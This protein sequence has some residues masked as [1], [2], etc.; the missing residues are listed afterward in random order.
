MAGDGANAMPTVAPMLSYEDAGA[1]SAWLARAFGF[2]ERFRY[3]E[4]DGRVSHVELAMD[5]GVVMLATPTPDYESPKRH[6]ER[7]EA[8]ARWSRSPYVIDGVLV[9]VDDADAHCERARAAGAT[10][11]SEPED[12][13]HGDRHY[14]AED[15]EGH[16]WMFAQRL[17]DVAPEEWGAVTA[18]NG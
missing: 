3:T 11:L 13:P 6:R 17:T 5:D 8:A 10:I 9:Y 12:Q 1:A 16:R 14:R 4:P 7:C 15:H 18:K 2:R